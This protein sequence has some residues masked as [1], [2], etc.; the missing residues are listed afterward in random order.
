MVV[1]GP[2]ATLQ[3]DGQPCLSILPVAGTTNQQ[4]DFLFTNP[5][6]G[7]SCVILGENDPAIRTQDGGCSSPI[8]RQM[9]MQLCRPTLVQY[10]D[11]E[12]AVNF[13]FD[14][15]IPDPVANADDFVI[16]EPGGGQHAGLVAT[17]VGQNTAKVTFSDYGERVELLPRRPQ[18]S[19][20]LRS[21]GQ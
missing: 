20:A 12:E 3:A 6:T 17:K 11:S 5:V 1:T 15:V 14:Q 19:T 7:T 4:W 2:P 21:T 8:E 9:N 16:V 13:V 10:D 18:R